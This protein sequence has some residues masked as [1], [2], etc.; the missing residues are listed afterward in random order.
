MNELNK[1]KK[2]LM[3][4]PRLPSTPCCRSHS[5]D[6]AYSWTEPSRFQISIPRSS[7]SRKALFA[8]LRISWWIQL[9]R[10]IDPRRF[11]FTPDFQIVIEFRLLFLCLLFCVFVYLRRR[12]GL[13]KFTCTMG[14]AGRFTLR[15]L[16]VSF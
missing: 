5:R 2:D 3:S 10:M 8:V 13:L 12:R 9:N 6:S 7:V 4:P 14:V 15:L 16:F 1:N 11:P